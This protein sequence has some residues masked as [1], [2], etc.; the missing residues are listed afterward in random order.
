MVA[1]RH[2]HVSTAHNAHKLI[3]VV[4]P[5]GEDWCASKPLRRGLTRPP[6]QPLHSNE[7][8]ENLVTAAIGIYGVGDGRYV[9]PKA[10]V[11][12]RPRS[13]KIH[14]AILAFLICAR[15]GPRDVLCD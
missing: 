8:W 2:Q 7:N 4:L 11:R 14:G 15:Q 10:R 13:M 3:H 1:G 6:I 5:R 9:P 12:L